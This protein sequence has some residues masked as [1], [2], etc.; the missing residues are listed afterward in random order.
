M[1]TPGFLFY[2]NRERLLAREF[3]DRPF[4]LL[5]IGAG[6]DS[7]VRL[8]SVF[9]NCEYHGVDRDLSYNLSRASLEHAD[10]FYTM[11]LTMCRFESIPEAFHD[12]IILSHVVE[13]LFN[14]ERVLR[15]LVTK[16]KRGGVVYVEWPS[17]RSLFLPSMRGTLNFCDDATH[18]RF[19]ARHELA[20]V[21][22]KAGCTIERFGRCRNGWRCLAWPAIVLKNYR[23][24]GCFEAS[25]FWELLGFADFIWARRTR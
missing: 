19:F 4:R 13:H 17:E 7:P 6:N 23:Q 21:L 25:D 14:G 24:R 1:G 18:V 11:D 9:P 22:E 12:V 20:H 2:K 3:G 8:K 5:D 10:R 16:L 15:E